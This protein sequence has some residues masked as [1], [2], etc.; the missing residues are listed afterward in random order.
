MRRSW[1][2]LYLEILDEEKLA[3]LP[4]AV[5]WRFVQLLLVAPERDEARIL[6]PAEHPAPDT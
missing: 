6:P 3:E 4:E 2:K 5:C 1:I